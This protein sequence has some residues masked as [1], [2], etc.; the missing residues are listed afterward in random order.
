V[1]I[2]PRAVVDS[3]AEIDPSADI[4]PY[5]VVEAGVTIGPETKL[6]PHAFVARGTTLGARVQV[7]P[8]ATVGHE[9]QDLSYHGARTYTAIG[10]DTIIREHASIHRGTN[11][12]STTIVGDR[13]FIMSTAHIAHNCALGNDVVLVNGVM[14]AG[15]VHVG[16][17]A[18]FGGGSGVHQFTRV[19]ELAMLRGNSS[20][21]GD[22]PPFTMIGPRGVVGLNVVGLRRAGVSPEER[23]ELRRAYR[24]LFRSHRPFRDVL[25]EVAPTIQTEPGRRFIEFLKAPSKRG[26]MRYSAHT[27]PQ[28]NIDD[29][30]DG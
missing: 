2:D 4:G 20:V 14:L 25:S 24:A 29:D 28:I 5:A 26:I 21:P 12:E 6:W 30:E 16:N 15:H 11:P 19:G 23:K 27:A 22:V 9:P 8:F 17:R 10:D 18:F 3:K 1:P 13:C 7:H